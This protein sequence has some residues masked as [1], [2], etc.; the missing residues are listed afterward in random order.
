MK[1][2]DYQYLKTNIKLDPNDGEGERIS[3]FW[4]KFKWNNYVLPHLPK[5]VK[6]LTYIDMGCNTG[7]L[8]KFAEEMGFRRSIGVD[9]NPEAVEK[10]IAYRSQVGGKYEISYG[11]MQEIIND[12]PMCDYMSFI[13]SHYYLLIRDW[14]ELLA[15]LRRK[16]RYVI[17]TTTKKKEYYCMASS[18]GRNV[19]KYFKDWKQVGYVPQPPMEG[20]LRPRSLASYCF[21]NPDL[22]RVSLERLERGSHMREAFYEQIEQGILPLETQYFKKLC[23]LK[24]RSPRE[25]LIEWMYAK[26]AMYEDV[27]KHG[28]KEPIIVNK[29]YRILD[30][31]HRKRILE[32]LGYKTTIIRMV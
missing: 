7:L 5:N 19:R 17:I 15:N 9:S 18:Y 14:L 16:V 31:N 3:E 4:D 29:H 23:R 28:I 6:N 30:G 27:K 10:G 11:K 12:L 1:F 32:F 22:E 25:G 26:V 8:L 24:K 21:E 20:N 2:T 13:N